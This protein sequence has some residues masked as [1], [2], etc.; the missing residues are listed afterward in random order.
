MLVRKNIRMSEEMAEWYES[1]AK[2][3]GVSQSN[4][5]VFA[6]N[7]YI[8]MNDDMKNIKELYSLLE[9]VATESVPPIE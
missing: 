7:S 6:L 8:K 4:L 1:E 3:L 2:R 5:M 9:D